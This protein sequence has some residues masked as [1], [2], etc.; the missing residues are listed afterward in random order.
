MLGM[1]QDDLLQTGSNQ[2]NGAEKRRR[3][4]SRSSGVGA[5]CSWTSCSSKKQLG[6]SSIS[7][8]FEQPLS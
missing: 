3:H 2:V 6:C 7:A 5:V 8:A 1:K 4:E